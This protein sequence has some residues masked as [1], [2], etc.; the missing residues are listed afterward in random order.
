MSYR[1]SITK[2]P[3]AKIATLLLVSLAIAATIACSTRPQSTPDDLNA[4]IEAIVDDSLATREATAATK[5]ANPAC[6]DV[7][8]NQFIFQRNAS[9]VA[10]LNSVIANLQNQLVDQCSADV[11]DP[12]VTTEALV[13]AGTDGCKSSDI[14]GR[15]VPTGLHKGGTSD[16]THARYSS[17]RDR[18][19]N[20]IIHWKH[21]NRPF[22][23]AKC[24]L[25]VEPLSTWSAE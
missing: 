3:R 15:D 4:T 1:H 19:N 5:A 2:K 25:Y 8:K 23:N 24:W 21:R 22:D 6:D 13:T 10:S 20:I 17:G 14:G 11:W 7:L 12:S 18:D 9:T 16:P